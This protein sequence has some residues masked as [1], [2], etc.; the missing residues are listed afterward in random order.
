MIR[1]ENIGKV[2]RTHQKDPGLRGSLNSLFNRKWIDKV[3]LKNISFNVGEGEIIGLVGANGAGKTTLLK[4][5]SGI[6]HPT[7][8]GATVN[9]SVPWLRENKF[10][11]EIA[12]IMGQKQ[13]LWWDLPAADCFKLLKEIYQIPQED[14]QKRV[15]EL[16]ERLAA[17]NILFTPIRK[18]SLGERMKAELI[19][20]LL[21][22]PK[23]IYLDEPTI[24][25]DFSA[26]KAIRGFIKDYI[27]EEKP[28][29]IL[30]SHYLA[31][32]ENLCKKV[33][34]LSK[35]EIVYQGDLMALRQN[36]KVEFETDT[37]A[38]I[39]LS[40][41]ENIQ[42]W[43][44]H[45]SRYSLVTDCENVQDVAKEIL[46]NFSVRSLSMGGEDLEEVIEEIMMGNS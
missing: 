24:G 26:Q 15:S 39:D 29:I 28:A 7:H 41:I 45:G 1:I 4:I 40:K 44:R 30:T 35:G 12:L 19:A 10:R 5:L 43:A 13:Q 31:D 42:T 14:Y 2:Y 9:G 22:K 25:L 18:L 17:Q 16:S 21:H 8:G 32:I 38:S 34:I 11:K 36:S 3:A 27:K 37:E 6:I 33:V 23:V 46:T 20:A